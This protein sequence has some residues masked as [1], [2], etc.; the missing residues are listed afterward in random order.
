MAFLCRPSP[1]FIEIAQKIACFNG[2]N[3][4]V[5]GVFTPFDQYQIRGSAWCTRSLTHAIF[6]TPS[7]WNDGSANSWK[8]PAIEAMYRNVQFWTTEKGKNN[9]LGFL[10]AYVQDF[11]P[12]EAGLQRTSIEDEYFLTEVCKLAK[13]RIFTGARQTEL[14]AVADAVCQFPVRFVN[15]AVNGEWRAIGASRIT[16]S[17]SASSYAQTNWAAVQA[18]QYNNETLGSPGP[19]RPGR[20]V[21]SYSQLETSTTAGAYY[22]S[23]FWAAL[24]AAVERDVPGAA[25]AWTR[26]TSS[27]TGI[28]NLATW[29]DGFASDPR[30]GAY[31]RNKS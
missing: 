23:Y 6:L 2:A 20:G 18:W 31:P 12:G 14:D 8:S 29:A 25:T 7:T 22:D 30:W 11:E 4:N 19:W 28:S 1:V 21:R 27:T 5:N 15:E 10:W 17:S 9:P 3:M 26:V 16:V 24:V 13:S